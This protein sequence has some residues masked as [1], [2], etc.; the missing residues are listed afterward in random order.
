MSERKFT[1]ALVAHDR[2]KPKMVSWFERHQVYFESCHIVA[3]GTTGALL[4][5]SLSAKGVDIQAVKSGPF[6]GDQ[7]IGSM[8]ASQSI[9]ALVFFEDVMTPQPHEVDIKALLRLAVL[10]NIPVACNEASATLLVTN[11]LL[12][13]L[14]K[15]DDEALDKE[16]SD[17][18]SQRPR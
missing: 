3:T 6:G 13:S 16:F 10:Y 11:P 18:F 4:M 14:K 15:T 1:F 5:K 9:D 12:R 17:Y 8:I 2:V 7:Q